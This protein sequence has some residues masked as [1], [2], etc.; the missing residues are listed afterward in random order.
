MEIVVGSIVVSAVL[1]W[2]VVWWIA[3]RVH[4]GW[5]FWLLWVLASTVGSI[6]GLFVGIVGSDVS[7]VLEAIPPNYGEAGFWAVVG[8]GVGIFQWLVLRWR[9]CRSGWWVLASI[10]GLAVAAVLAMAMGFAGDDPYTPSHIARV[11][12]VGGAMA[13]IMQ[14]FVLRRQVSRA[15]WWVLASTAG[16]AV[17]GQVALGTI[18][19]L[20]VAIVG[21]GFVLGGITGL[22]LVWLLRQ[23]IPEA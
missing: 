14:W 10:L 12:V 8:A 20:G 3:K 6:T 4:L 22:A 23:P 2:F 1:A 11:L 21:G 5:G 18:F 17:W 9:V 16:W 7:E 15:G 19:P 13:G